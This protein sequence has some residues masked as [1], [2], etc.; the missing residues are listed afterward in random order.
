MAENKLLGADVDL[1]EL[2]Q[3]TKNYTGAELEAVVKS[4]SSSAFHRVHDIMDFTKKNLSE[5]VIVIRS[6]ISL[7]IV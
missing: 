5:E 2:A 7:Y 6:V 4:A 1:L 3:L